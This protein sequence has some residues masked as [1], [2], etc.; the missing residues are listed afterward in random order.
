[1]LAIC[2]LSLGLLTIATPASFATIHETG[3]LR[4]AHLSPNTPAV[5][6]YLYPFGNPKAE[7]VLH[8]VSY[9]T[10]SAYLPANAGFYTVAMRLAGKSPSTPAVLSTAVRVRAGGAYTVAGM[11]PLSGL[12]LE[13][14]P[15]QL[16]APP[17]HVMV[18]VIQASMAQ[19][20]VTVL[21]GS[22]VIGNGLDFT[23]VTPYQA[24]SGGTYTVR[25]SGDTGSTAQPVTL[26]AGSIH[27]LVILD[28]PSHLHIVDL[29]DAV[30]SSAL[31]AG[32]PD[33]GPRLHVLIIRYG[34]IGFAQILGYTLRMA[35]A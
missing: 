20:N 28:G 19:H 33:T 6:V 30:G 34:G 11:G 1:M 24:I 18:R 27:T 25:V 15:S 17:G 3:W 13:V 21:A 26:L 31:P 22:D 35:H 10:V 14:V 8:H 9:G 29:V 5:D 23:T 4:L 7:L 12:R 2:T 16:A 32:A